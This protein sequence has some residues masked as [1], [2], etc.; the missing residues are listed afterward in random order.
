[1]KTPAQRAKEWRDKRWIEIEAMPKK[2]C[3]C[4]CGE[5]MCPINIQGNPVDYIK[6]HKQRGSKRSTPP[7][8]K[9]GETGLTS[10]ERQ[11]RHRE[12]KYAEI[13]QMPKIPC[14]CGCGT[15]IAP[16]GRLLRPVKYALGH[17]PD[18]ENTRFPKG[19]I[20]WN[21]N[22]PR[23]MGENHPLWRGGVG[24]LPYGPGFTRRFK[25]IIRQRDQYTCQH[26]GIT[27]AEHRLTLQIHHM[28][29]DKMNNDP[30]NLV[31]A[32]NKCNIW[33][34]YHPAEPFINPEV[35]ARTHDA[36]LES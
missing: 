4:G 33:A 16:I 25:R 29:F 9:I 26:C 15:M 30:T 7:W 18:G 6:G 22:N 3:A 12:K 35:W 36:P 20:P 14:A 28:D 8:N 31:T 11:R 1:M 27:Q 13:E 34:N 10:A 19:Q 24:S 2:Q 17:N 32:C 5:W 21:K 23:Y